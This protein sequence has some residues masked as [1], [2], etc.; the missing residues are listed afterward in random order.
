MLPPAV[1]DLGRA[2]LDAAARACGTAKFVAANVSNLED[3]DTMLPIMIA[4]HKA[5]RAAIKAARPDLPVGVSLAMLDD[6][7]VGADS[8]R[9]ARRE[10]LY[11]AWL[12]A[13]RSDDFLGVQNYERARYDAQG[14]LPPPAGAELNAMGSEIYAASLANAV[15]YAHT[16]TGLPIMIT[17]HGLGTDND[18]LRAQF[19]PAALRELQAAIQDGVPVKG[20]MHW[21]L[22][23]NF[24]WIFGYGPKYG[25]CAVDRTTFKR[26]PKPSAAVLGG[27][28]RR[29]SLRQQLS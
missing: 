14:R 10:E 4:G 9:D 11:G 18:A 6:Q 20:Y 15:R 17:E 27:I 24:E 1:W 12:E 28:A 25:L 5:G 8:L 2:T 3:I 22:L 23:D 7:A 13:A 26:T 16:A 29:N 19:I 21:S